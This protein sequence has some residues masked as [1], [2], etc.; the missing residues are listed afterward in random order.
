MVSTALI[1]LSLLAVG[2]FGLQSCR[3]VRACTKLNQAAED[4]GV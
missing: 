4:D 2:Q 1:C 3:T